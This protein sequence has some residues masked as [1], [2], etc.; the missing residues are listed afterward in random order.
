MLV[1]NLWE[2]F[3]ADYLAGDRYHEYR[4]LIEQSLALG[5]EHWTIADLNAS[6]AAKKIGPDAKIFVHRH[7]ID[8]DSSG[9]RSFFEIEKEYGI[10]ATY[11]FR[12][13]TLDHALMHEINDYGSEVGYHYEELATYAKRHGLQYREDVLAHMDAITAEF[14]KNVLS[15]EKSLGF[16][17]RSVASHGDFANR[18]TGVRNTQILKNKRLRRRLK[19]A[20]ESYDDQLMNFFEAYDSDSLRRRP[21]EGGSPFDAIRTKRRI[22]LLTHPRHWRAAP[23]ENT[24]DNFRR[25]ADDIGWRLNAMLN[26]LRTIAKP[27]QM[28]KAWQT[29]QEVRQLPR[30][31]VNLG[32]APGAEMLR[33]KFTAMHPAFLLLSRKQLGA[34]LIDLSQYKDLDAYLSGSG[35]QVSA[36]YV[37]HTRRRA[38]RLGYTVRKFRFQDH[39]RELVAINTSAPMRQGKKMT[40]SYLRRDFTLPCSNWQTPYGVFTADGVLV[41]YILLAEQGEVGTLDR[42]LGHAD[43]LANGVMYLL[44]TEVI[45]DLIR[46]GPRRYCFYDMW[47]GASDGLRMF[48]RRLGF[49]PYF[50]R[51]K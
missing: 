29:L 18:R 12:L 13:R 37:R 33:K 46:E 35:G 9:A 34:C 31:T 32:T 10:R 38:Q 2:R 44:T 19:I 21:Y 24:K 45:G 3:Y 28:S 4:R 41:G 23:L 36:K 20:C 22:C 27:T 5:F 48:K 39:Q 11:Y 14:E 8:T 25:V 49:K 43:H 6:I 51:W 40:Q 17:I 50:V 42:I 47:F 15:L 1:K 7:D 26:R 30:V 16:K